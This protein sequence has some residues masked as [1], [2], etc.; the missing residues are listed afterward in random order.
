MSWKRILAGTGIS[1][2]VIGV[3]A[4]ASRMSRTG[5]QLISMT[6]AKLHSLKEDGLTIRIDT[7]LKNPNAGTLK[8][9]Y[10]LVEL[11]YGAKPIGSSQSINQDITIPAYGEA[12]IDGIMVKISISGLFTLGLGLYKLLIQKTPAELSVRT[13]TTIDLGW[14]KL[15]YEKIDPSTINPIG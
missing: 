15:P 12:H 11:I 14:K 4:Y 5:S 3:I 2:A 1:A 6:T 7:V 8:I 9:K 10:P 13:I